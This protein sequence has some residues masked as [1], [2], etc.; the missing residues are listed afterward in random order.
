MPWTIPNLLLHDG[1][2]R[3]QTQRSLGFKKVWVYCSNPD[4]HHNADLDVEH[5]PMR[6][7]STTS[8]PAWSARPAVIAA[9]MSTLPS[10][11]RDV[12]T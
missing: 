12:L 5:L 2:C 10:M 6:S 11:C 7:L 8:N 9:Q 4:C 1:R 3:C